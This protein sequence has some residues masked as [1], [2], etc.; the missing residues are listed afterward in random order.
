M[1]KSEA[2]AIS[3]AV[4]AQL[5]VAASAGKLGEGISFTA[6]H[7]MLPNFEREDFNTLIV[8]TRPR[9]DTRTFAARGRVQHD[10]VIEVL[11]RKQ[12]DSDESL[13][14]DDLVLLGQK[15][16]DFWEQDDTD[17][18]QTRTLTG[19]NERLVGPVEARFVDDAL[20]KHQLIVSQ[21]LLTFRALR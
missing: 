14:G 9:S 21:V 17:T 7:L 4:A 1:S 12:V 5:S 11:A 13:A 2:T 20:K 8:T 15:I 18:G 10:Y 6:R 16:G 19:R 3:E